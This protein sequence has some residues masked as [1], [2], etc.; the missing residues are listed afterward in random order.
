MDERYEIGKQIGKGGGGLVYKGYDTFLRRDVAIKRIL[1]GGKASDEDIKVAARNLLAEA[2]TLSTLNHPNIVTV[3]DV[4]IDDKGG[5]V[6]ME[7]LDGETLFDTVERGVMTQEDFVELAIQTME[8][9]IAAHAMNVMHRDLKPTNVMVIWQPSGRFQSKILDFGL[10]KFSK[11]PSVQ[12]LNQDGTVMG[13]IL[14]MAPE[15]FERQHLDDRTD[16]YSI[17]CVY[18]HSLCG[19]YPY[20]GE[21]SADVM[22][23]HLEHRV[24]PLDILRPDLAPSICQWVMW[25]INRDIDNR[26]DSAQTALELLPRHPELEKEQQLQEI[27]VEKTGKVRVMAVKPVQE[28]EPGANVPKNLIKIPDGSTTMMTGGA[29]TATTMLAGKPGR[30]PDLRKAKKAEGSGGKVVKVVMALAA[31]VAAYFIGLKVIE[32]KHENDLNLIASQKVVTADPKTIDLLLGFIY[33]EKTTLQQ[34]Q[35]ARYALTRMEGGRVDELLLGKIKL[36]PSSDARLTLCRILGDRKMADAVPELLEAYKSATTRV[37]RMSIL[38]LARRLVET[39]QNSKPS[40]DAKGILVDEGE[41][42]VHLGNYLEGISNLEK[43]L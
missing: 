42:P 32:F 2:Q 33:S 40:A 31:V 36:A 35:V 5:F 19:I 25:L 23:S 8:A 17:G 41:R 24:T 7:L 14:F 21:T 29:G 30:K 26:P 20:D 18:Y 28:P 4:G 6:V 9:L 38:K 12:T 13:S 22:N 27:P 15:Q 1:A 43:E 10:A 16:L 39:A 11:K 34:R 3:F 37:E